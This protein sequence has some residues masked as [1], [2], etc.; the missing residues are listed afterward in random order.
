MRLLSFPVIL[1][2]VRFQRQQESDQEHDG[3]RAHAKVDASAS[4]AADRNQHGFGEGGSFAA[5]IIQS[6]KFSGL[7][8][9]NDLYEVGA[10]ERLD[11]A[12]EHT[13]YDRQD[14]ELVL[15]FQDD[16][17]QGD[18]KI[19]ADTDHDQFGG[20]RFSGKPAEDQGC[21]E[22]Y[23]LRYQKSQEQAGGVQPQS[24]SVSGRHIDD[25]VHAVN[26]KEKRQQEEQNLPAFF[27]FAEDTAQPAEAGGEI[28]AGGYDLVMCLG[29]AF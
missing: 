21:R 14:P 12:L 16:P 27:Q 20:L 5:D 18:Q 1:H 2:P 28:A 8:R 3:Q 15:L 11:R 10:G 4:L 19:G 17:V 9:G 29:V 23:D 13:Y 25:S 22:G 7:V 26:I 24:R 6:E